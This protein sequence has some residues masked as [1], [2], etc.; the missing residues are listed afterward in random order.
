M[1]EK[2]LI[3]ELVKLN[4]RQ[5]DILDRLVQAG[6]H[7]SEVPPATES[8]SAQPDNRSTDD[9]TRPLRV[10]D[11]VKVLNATGIRVRRDTVCTVLK[12]GKRVTSVTPGG[13]KIVR[14]PHNLER[15]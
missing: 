6:T 2:E 10:G 5:A 4:I 15:V 3:A 1:S 7:M 13:I 11:R 8:R 14:A 9:T 12:V